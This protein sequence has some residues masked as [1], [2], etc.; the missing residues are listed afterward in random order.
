MG[1]T[2]WRC[3]VDDRPGQQAGIFAFAWFAVRLGLADLPTGV[4]WR[5]LHGVAVLGGIGFTMSLFIASLAFAG[6]SLEPV[7]KVGILLGSA[8]S[9]LAG[10]ALVASAS[11]AKAGQTS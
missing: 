3:A 4:S 11:P 8:A 7:E 10:L 1:A 5:Q 6:G 9:A 2:F